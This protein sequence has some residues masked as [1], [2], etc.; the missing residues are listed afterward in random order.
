MMPNVFA[1]LRERYQDKQPNQIIIGLMVG[2]GGTLIIVGLIIVM[3]IGGSISD[4]ASGRAVFNSDLV[5]DFLKGDNHPGPKL[6]VILLQPDDCQ[7]CFDIGQMADSLSQPALGLN[8]VAVRTISTD[9]RDG[10]ELIDRYKVTQ[11]PTLLISG[12][13]EKDK[14]FFDALKEVGDVVDGVFVFRKVVP[15]YL[16]LASGQIKGLM[17]AIYLTDNSCTECYDVMLHGQALTG[18]GISLDSTSTIDVGSDEGKALVAK[19][20][21]SG[22]PTVLMSGDISPY[23]VINTGLEATLGYYGSTTDDGTY[24]FTKLNEMGTYRD[25]KT[26]KIVEVKLEQPAQ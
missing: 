19:Y 17:S 23:Q 22:V 9:S 7:D 12:E 8:I 3:M 16:D 14:M 4:L 13:L 25:L 5:P 15:P 1:K 26:G 10:R 24:I 2:V 21:I 20:S 6:R 18:L 11:V